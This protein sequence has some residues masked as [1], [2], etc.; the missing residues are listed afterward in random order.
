MPINNPSQP[1]QIIDTAFKPTI[2]TVNVRTAGNGG[3][4]VS[5]NPLRRG[6]NITN[7]ASSEVRI[8][9]TD[10]ETAPH[11]FSLEPGA[12]Y[13]MPNNLGVTDTLYSF[14]EGIGALLV[15]EFAEV[16]LVI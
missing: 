15:V 11:W 8:S 4:V 1:H 14:T 13:E 12:F 9:F 3:L 16:P 7:L 2:P 10:S 6:L 5:E